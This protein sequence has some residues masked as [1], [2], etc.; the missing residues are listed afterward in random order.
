MIDYKLLSE[1]VSD[2]ITKNDN[3]NID[4][5]E[6][7][8]TIDGFIYDIGFMRDSLS[9]LYDIIDSGGID[10]I[11]QI[12]SLVDALIMDYKLLI[13]QYREYNDICSKINHIIIDLESIVIN[14]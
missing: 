1:M 10:Q 14:S 9:M 3:V 2:I 11:D 8:S 5:S 13:Y 7:D 4:V 12:N 6:D